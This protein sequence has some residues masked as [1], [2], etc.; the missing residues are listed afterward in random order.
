MPFQSIFTELA[1]CCSVPRLS[2]AGLPVG[3]DLPPFWLYPGDDGTATPA[4]FGPPAHWLTPVSVPLEPFL[5]RP[6]RL[7]HAPNV[8][9]LP[10]CHV[11]TS[12]TVCWARPGVHTCEIV[13]VPRDRMRY[14]PGAVPIGGRM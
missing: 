5:V 11:A 3:T 10:V 4:T 1:A 8:D 6:V 9:M 12:A 14:T 2:T 7:V 13:L